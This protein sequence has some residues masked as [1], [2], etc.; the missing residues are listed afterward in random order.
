MTIEVLP[1]GQTCNL[2][3]PYCY[4]HPLRD[5]DNYGPDYDMDKLKQ[6]LIKQIKPWIDLKGGFTIFGGEPLLMPIDD[7]EELIS[8]GTEEF[9]E[10]VAEGYGVVSIQSNGVL[11]TDRHIEIFKKYKVTIGIS[12]DGPEECNDSRWAG[13]LERTRERTEMSMNNIKRLIEEGIY[14]SLIITLWRGNIARERR[15]KF[16]A[17]IKEMHT[18]G[19]CGARLHLLEVDHEKVN[20]WAPSTEE[21]IEFLVDIYREVKTLSGWSFDLFTDIKNL[22]RGTDKDVSCIYHACDPY[23][24]N[25]V[26]GVDGE[27][28]RV[29]CGRADHTGVDWEKAD[30]VGYERYL[31]L[32][33]TSFEDG[34][35]GGCRFFLMCKGQCPG[36]GE[37][38]DWRNK[39]S[40][41]EVLL[42]IYGMMESELLEEGIEPFSMASYREDA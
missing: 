3:C 10:N 24:T 2:M 26:Q 4:E 42:G 32:Y 41:C 5:A 30:D 34:G 40:H 22:L 7:L 36:T 16:K 27:G 8:W 15:S 19:V 25:A 31:G 37:L 33:H 12:V 11:I 9:K 28:T 39:T 29:N 13:T 20:E 18:L 23:T 21:Y 6:G 38:G 14:V 1:V 35:C 17:W